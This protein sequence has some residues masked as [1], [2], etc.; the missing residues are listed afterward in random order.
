MT[1]MKKD[2]LS[3][4]KREKMNKTASINAKKVSIR[5]TNSSR[6][7]VQWEIINKKKRKKMLKST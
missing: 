6:F 3:K 7:L 1:V 4:M 2:V 5:Y